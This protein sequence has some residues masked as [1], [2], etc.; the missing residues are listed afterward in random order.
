MSFDLVYEK[1]KIKMGEMLKDKVAIVTGG[2][3]GIGQ[4]TAVLF[5][6]E[7][8]KVAVADYEP[9]GGH[10]T[11]ELIEGEGGEAIFIE[12][13]VSKPEHVEKMVRH[14]AATYGRL[15]V[16]FNNAGVGETA[17]VTEASLEHWE[18]VLAINLGGVFLGCKYAIPEM[19]KNGGGSIINNASI[20]AEV[21]FSEAAAYSASKHGV[22]GLTQTIAIDYAAQAIRANTVC[23][24]FIKTPMVMK[25]LDEETRDYIAGLHPL[26]RM[27]EPEEVAEAV[28]FLAS[29]RSSFVTGTCLFVDGGYTAR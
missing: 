16:L 5:G 17:K 12:T 23:P 6:R 19:I 7:G 24:G 3:S 28:L 22:V 8:A 14:T 11:V 21:G 25:G 4:A 18:R 26:G 9:T 15:D 10:E 20:L 29:D 1:E 2:A 27:G 13:D